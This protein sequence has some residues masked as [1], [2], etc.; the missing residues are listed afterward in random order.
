M[1]SIALAE[2][3]AES[4]P[5]TLRDEAERRLTALVES[6]HVNNRTIG[7]A[8]AHAAMAGYQQGRADALAALLTTAQAAAALGVGDSRVRQLARATGIGW[9]VGRDWLFR[10]E[11]I[12]RLRARPDSRR[13]KE[14]GG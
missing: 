3:L 4:L 8:I 1:I 9:N 6:G 10:P 14:E 5:A 7:L 11:D 12:E 13:R 2:G